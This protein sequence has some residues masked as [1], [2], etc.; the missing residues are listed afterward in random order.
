VSTPGTDVGDTSSNFQGDR[1]K[2]VTQ[3]VGVN[4]DPPATRSQS[5]PADSVP[6][7]APADCL[8]GPYAGLDTY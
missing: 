3:T 6:P 1:E 8:L 7:L 5:A 4:P 2:Q